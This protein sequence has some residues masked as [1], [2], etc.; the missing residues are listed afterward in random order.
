MKKSGF[1]FLLIVLIMSIGGCS[2]GVPVASSCIDDVYT[3]ERMKKLKIS[4]DVFGDSYRWE[5]TSPDGVLSVVSTSK[6]CILIAQMPG[7]YKLKLIVS[8]N[9]SEFAY[10]SDVIVKKE[11]VAYSPYIS[12]VYDFMPAPGQFVNAVPEF[13]TN[14]TKETMRRK[15]AESICGESGGL[16]SL[17]ACGGYIV[18][19]F[20]HTII[21]AVGES[22]FSVYGN[23]MYTENSKGEITAANAEPGVVYVSLD[24]NQNG[25]P[26]DVWY[27]LA[28]SEYG[29][30]STVKG[31]EIVYSKQGDIN[32]NIPWRDNRGGSGLVE[33]NMIH[34]QDYYPLWM[35]KLD[36]IYN[37]T[38]LP[39]NGKEVRPSYF[40][41]KPY[42]WG[43]VD[44]WPNSYEDKN[45]F[46]IEWAVDKNGNKVN[47]P[48]ADFIKV[49]TGVSQACGW[50]GETST[51]ITGAKDRHI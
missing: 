49:V 41:Q 29:K 35:D 1:I 33:K 45:S 50:L 13:E 43:Y 31:Y 24:V 8:D 16:L 19:G 30:Q 5:V 48:G 40:I 2:D 6:E 36:L 38:L 34:K 51:E 9:G 3:V 26:D 23:A 21:N 32:A 46:D 22:D 11:D 27:E 44:N 15:A 17:G 20:D 14:D 39:K 47:L 42:E 25:K 10:N 7:R 4:I 18:F 12:T 37:V 28:G